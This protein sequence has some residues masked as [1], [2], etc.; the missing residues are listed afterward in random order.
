MSSD[1]TIL[2]GKGEIRQSPKAPRLR[3]RVRSPHVTLTAHG[4]PMIWLTGGALAACLAMTVVLI[5]G[6]CLLRIRDVLAG[7]RC[8]CLQRR[9]H[10]DDG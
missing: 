4:E 1:A 7:S 3:K 10:G 8:P 5:W 2:S 6:H 9:R